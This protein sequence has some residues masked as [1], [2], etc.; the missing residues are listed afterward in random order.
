MVVGIRGLQEFLRLMRF[1]NYP[2]LRDIGLDLFALVCAKQLPFAHQVH[3][4][5]LSMENI[6]KLALRLKKDV[7]QRSQV[8]D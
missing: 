1:P 4:T 3:Q 7:F 5:L 2:D 6:L 8:H